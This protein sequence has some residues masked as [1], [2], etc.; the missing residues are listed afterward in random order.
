MTFEARQAHFRAIVNSPRRRWPLVRMWAISTYVNRN[1]IGAVVGVQPFGGEGLSGTGPKAGGRQHGAAGRRH[2]TDLD[3]HGIP[4]FN[5][6]GRP[7]PACR[8]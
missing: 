6:T 7:A 1:M 2:L 3:L 5:A 8:V 4:A